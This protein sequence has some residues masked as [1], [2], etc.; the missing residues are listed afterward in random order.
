MNNSWVKLYRSL[1]DDAVF[2]DAEILKVWIWILCKVAYKKE[3]RIVKKQVIEL[4]PGQM[5][6]SRKDATEFLN[7]SERK[8]R[9]AIQVL[10]DIGCISKK[11]SNKF[12][13]INVIKWGFFQ[14][15]AENSDQQTSNKRPTDDQQTSSLYNKKKYKN[16]KNINKYM[17]STP[18]CTHARDYTQGYPQPIG[19]T[20]GK[21]VLVLT[22]AQMDNLLELMPIDVFD[23]YCDKL[24]SWIKNKGRNIK[25]HY[26]LILKWYKEDYGE[27][28]QE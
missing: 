18:A 6:I 5:I 7:I 28:V 2:D 13:L 3:T 4:E 11:T 27:Q 17:S 21:G 22:D 20:I 14:G 1:V 23:R 26:G 12:T 8:Y 15:Q 9:N 19:G 24:S 16:I 25:D 10:E